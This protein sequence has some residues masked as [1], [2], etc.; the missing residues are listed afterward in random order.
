MQNV[1]TLKLV[2]YGEVLDISHKLSKQQSCSTLTSALIKLT[3]RP[4]GLVEE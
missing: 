4:P 2:L 3:T 1:T